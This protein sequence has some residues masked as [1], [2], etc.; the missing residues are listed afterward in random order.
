EPP[1]EPDE[2]VYIDLAGWEEHHPTWEEANLAWIE[3]WTGREDELNRSVRQPFPGPLDAPL[4]PTDDC[5]IGEV[6]TSSPTPT[7]S[8][9]PSPT[10]EETPTPTPSPSPTPEPTPTPTPVPAPTPT[11]FVEPPVAPP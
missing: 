2:E 11:P 4:A 8:P 9:T 10:P 7:A 1:P 3:E 5:V 6:P